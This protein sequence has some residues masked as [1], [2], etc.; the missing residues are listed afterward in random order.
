MRIVG[1]GTTAGIPRVLAIDNSG[2][3]RGVTHL[4]LDR[5][6]LYSAAFRELLAASGVEAV[7]LPARS[8]NLKGYASHCTPFD[9]SVAR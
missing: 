6:P 1:I 5:D 3:L 2:F 4:L 7:R 8:P 9:R